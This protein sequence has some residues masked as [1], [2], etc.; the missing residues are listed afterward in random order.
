MPNSDIVAE[1]VSPDGKYLAMVAGISTARQTGIWIQDLRSRGEPWPITRTTPGNAVAPAFSP[2]GQLLAYTAN[3]TGR[4]Q[5]YVR[6]VSG[7]TLPVQVSVTGGS[8]P[9]WSRD[10]ERL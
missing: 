3:S 1:A 5:V 8:Q 2:D 10:G 7:E 6:R 4:D 9:A